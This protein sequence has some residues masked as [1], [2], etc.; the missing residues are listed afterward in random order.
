M[1][2]MERLQLAEDRLKAVMKKT[3]KHSPTLSFR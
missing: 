1:D 3:G 2:P